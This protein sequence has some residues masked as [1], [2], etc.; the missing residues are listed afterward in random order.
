M[1]DIKKYFNLALLGIT[2]LL[3]INHH[4]VQSA[5]AYYSETNAPEFYGTTQITLKVGDELNLQEAKYRIYAR[6]FED[7]DLT[8]H[9]QVKSENVDETTP[10]TYA[11]VY[12]V[13]DSHQ[14]TTEITVPVIV[15]DDS[16]V[17]PSIQ[18][19]L[20]D[21]PSVWNMSLV[22]THRAN[23]GDRQH[24]GVFLPQ[25]SN[26]KVKMISGDL[27][28][29]LQGLNNDADTEQS[30]QLN[31]DKTEQLVTANHDIVLFAR[32]AV[33]ENIEKQIIEIEFVDPAVKSVQYY[34]DGD[35]EANFMSD[36]EQ[37]SG[38][39]AVIE[40]EVITVLVPYADRTKIT[41]PTYFGNAF[42]TL[43]EFLYYWQEV[44]D[45]FDECLGL[46]FN[47]EE[48][49]DQ[50]VRSRYT[51]KADKDSAGAA[52][53][54]I[55]HVA[56]NSASVASFFQR[57]WGGLHEIAHGYQGSLGSNGMALGEVSNN[58][59]GWFFQYCSLN[60]D[61]FSQNYDFYG[62]LGGVGMLDQTEHKYN[63][64]RLSGETF[65]QLDVYYRLYALLNLLE[66][67]DSYHTYADINKWY[68]R[69]V[70]D[71]GAIKNQEAYT[72][73]IAEKYG[74]NV[75]PYFEAWGVDIS[76]Q[77]KSTLDVGNYKYV[78]ILSDLVSEAMATEIKTKEHLH[79]EYALVS[80]ELLSKYGLNGSL[81]LT[82][83]IQNLDDI[84]GKYVYL[85]DGDQPIAKVKITGEDSCV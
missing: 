6:D 25:G 44:V 49:I 33:G 68:R 35:D 51:I 73:A 67:F 46:E 40:N 3:N 27:N 83:Q 16:N 70:N 62:N 31:K 18:R 17:N 38:N 19:T 52:Y 28:I 42:N 2:A 80:N 66:S 69:Y 81:D 63:L 37:D 48:A 54:S 39:Y 5:N 14:N 13:T 59:L 72:L 58:I 41:A 65:S 21:L 74:Y 56:I 20:Y 43:D 64:N 55:S 36:W 82:I 32:T 34:H 78:S 60:T 15:S 53:Y 50:N 76:D 29:Q 84:I 45:F 85:M 8:Q 10:G 30:T 9:I 26:V 47:P 77:T 4:S 7:G 1:F 11:V 23:S 24:L 57:N 61:R 22:G 79:G 71:K 12:T 75:V